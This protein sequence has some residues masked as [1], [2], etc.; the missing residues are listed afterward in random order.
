MLL[1]TSASC[2]SGFSA[3]LSS[4]YLPFRL[5][6][7]VPCAAVIRQSFAKRQVLGSRQETSGTPDSI[8]LP[9]ARVYVV[10]LESPV[11]NVACT[12]DLPE[13]WC[14]VFWLMSTGRDL[15]ATS[16]I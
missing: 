5:E 12:F 10:G 15:R 16:W 7:V 9:T 11:W 4:E 2:A 8:S 1:P 6:P 3:G 13:G 14:K